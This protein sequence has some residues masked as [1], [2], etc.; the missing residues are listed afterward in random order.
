M[1]RLALLAAA[2]MEG[3][4]TMRAR[5]AMRTAIWVSSAAI[6]GGSSTRATAVAGGMAGVA[7][8][9]AGGAAGEGVGA[10]GVAVVVGAVGGAGGAAAPSFTA[11]SWTSRASSSA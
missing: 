1:A 2:P 9:G 3:P 8:T 6:V 7:A 4:W 11:S 5:A 10:R